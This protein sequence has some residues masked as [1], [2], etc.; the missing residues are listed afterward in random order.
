MPTSLTGSGFKLTTFICLVITSLLAGCA[1]KPYQYGTGREEIDRPRSPAMDEQFQYGQ[2]NALLDASDWIWPGSLFTKLLLWDKDIDSH[3]ID[4]ETVETLRAYLHENDMQDVQVL[5]NAYNPGNQWSRLFN[6][7]NVSAG[8][9][10]TVGVI[11][12]GLYTLL[13]GRFFGGDA[14]NPYTNTIY[15]YSNDESIALHEGGHAKDFGRR[16]L[17]GTHAAIYNLPLA[18]LYYEA[19][20]TNETLG[21]LR[22]RNETEARKDAHKMLYPAYST[23]VAGNFGRVYAGPLWT[24]LVIPGHMAGQITA[25][26]VEPAGPE[27]TTIAECAI[28]INSAENPAEP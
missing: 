22:C 27:G 6:N 25:S 11:S 23:Y 1:S 15:L 2:P 20:A 26:R 5:V 7:R 17:K 3:Q 24:L 4:P 13:P 28:P 14:Y 19:R 12:V 8:W 10:Y 18:P 16:E 21:Y 9:R